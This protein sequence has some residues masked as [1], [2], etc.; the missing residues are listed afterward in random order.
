MEKIRSVVDIVDIVVKVVIT[1]A[2][3]LTDGREAGL[4]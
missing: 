4:D 3:F 2:L 1:T